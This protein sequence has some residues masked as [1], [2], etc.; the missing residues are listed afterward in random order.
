MNHIVLKSPDEIAL[1]AEGGVKLRRVASALVEATREGM[2]LKE[3]D[4]LARKLMKQE[5]GE[6][7]FLGYKSAWAKKPYPA[8]ICASVNDVIVHGLPGNYRLTKGDALKIDTGLLYKGFYTDL[9][10]TV[11][12]G[13]IAPEAE[14][15]INVT[16]DALLLA[17]DQCVVGNTVGDIGFAI[18]AYVRKNGFHVAKGLTG[19]GIG[20][21]LHESPVV[22]NE[23]KPG[24]GARLEAGMVLAIEPMVVQ[25]S[26]ETRE[27]PE[28]ESFA[29]SDG[30]LSAHF[31]ETVAIT[32]EG[33]K[34]LTR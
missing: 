7:A 34:V 21:A 14:R 5:G 28:D 9:A 2:P 15:L 18:N 29:T 12:I 22:K 32:P 1:M 3:L 19:H 20:R 11:A 30:G 17:I 26:G 10:V 24:T 33:P 27:V 31:E 8:A 25:G 16:R 23:A 13:E 4:Q 6:P